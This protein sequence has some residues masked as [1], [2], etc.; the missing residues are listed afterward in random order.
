M[1]TLVTGGTG[2]LGR[3]LVAA[4]LEQGRTVRV[5]ARQGSDVTGLD[6]AEV[7]RGDVTSR[8]DLTGAMTGATRVFHLAAETRDEQPLETYRAVN[9]DAVETLLELA[10]SLGIERIVH[11]SS[12]FAI[13]RTGE[14]R[15]PADHV[16]D[17]Y[18]THDPS[19]MHGPREESKYDAEHAVNQ[20]VSLSEPV[21]ALIPTMIYGPE[22]SPVASIEDLRPGNRIV[23]MLAEHAAGAYPGIPGDGKQIWNLVHV[24]DVVAGHLA[25]MDADDDSAT[26]PPPAWNH[27][28]YLLGGENVTVADLFARFETLAGIPAPKVLG[29]GSLLRKLFGGGTGFSKERFAMDRHSWAYTSAMA[30]ADFGYHGRPLDEGLAQTVEWMTNCGLVR[31]SGSAG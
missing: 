23:R 30:E 15:Q 3:H 6:G 10:P 12:Y 19:D 18:W 4:L 31:S 24:S 5:L 11:T 28:H 2:F 17:E 26:W 16:A 7:V 25:A 8:E 20:R 14:P 1:T 13:G 29:Q 22:L 9:V 21:L 27:W